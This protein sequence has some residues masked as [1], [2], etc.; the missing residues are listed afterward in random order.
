MTKA[1][2]AALG[3][4][5]A[6]GVLILLCPIVARAQD[7]VVLRS[8]IEIPG[9]VKS[10]KRGSLSFDTDEMD[11]ISIDLGDVVR[12]S[13]S[14]TFE[15]TLADGR[16]FLGSLAAA[17]TGAVVVVGGQRADTV[18]IGDIVAILSVDHGFWARTN[19]YL[20]VGGTVAQA[21]A[22]S[23]FLVGGLFAYRG[24]KWGFRVS[25]DAYWQQQE[26]ADD[27]GNT[28]K[29]RTNRFTL[30]SSVS[31]F[32]GSR[33][34]VQGTGDFEHNEELDLDARVQFGL[35]G[36][37]DFIENQAVELKAGAGLAT[38]TESYVGLE[39]ATSAEVV[40]GG[41]LDIFDLG[42]VDLYTSLIS[43]TNLNESGRYRLAFDGRISWEIISDFYI[44]FTVVER[45]D[46]KPPVEGALKRDYQYGLTV[47][48]SWS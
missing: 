40:V 4:L 15:V 20:D 19:G 24:P 27:L 13:S 8:G 29:Q 9:E 47:G 12:L 22:L 32:L 41:A 34:A 18:A 36:L 6:G 17:D 11:V 35:Q 44:G 37:H 14:S 21:N 10:A 43:Y 28:F 39:T 2:G 3:A 26:S 16:V 46:S 45:Y 1:M 38:N 31:R 25:A 30:G 42:A 48:W 33:W 23:S 7:Q 5:V